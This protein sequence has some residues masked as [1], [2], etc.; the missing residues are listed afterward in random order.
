MRVWKSGDALH[1]FECYLDDGQILNIVAANYLDAGAIATR[2][3][4]QLDGKPTLRRIAA[5][6]PYTG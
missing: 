5:I 6:G 3:A 4:R 2:I 1:L